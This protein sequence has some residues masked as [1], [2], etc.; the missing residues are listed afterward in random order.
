MPFLVLVHIVLIA[1]CKMENPAID[2]F[3]MTLDA[4]LSD[5]NK[6]DGSLLVDDDNAGNRVDRIQIINDAI[7]K[8]NKLFENTDDKTNKLNVTHE[9]LLLTQLRSDIKIAILE[10]TQRVSAIE[11]AASDIKIAILEDTNAILEETQRVSAI[12]KAASDIEKAIQN[13]TYFSSINDVWNTKSVSFEEMDAT[14]F[15]RT[16]DP[17]TMP[18]EYRNTVDNANMETNVAASVSSRSKS[19]QSSSAVDI[20]GCSREF[21]ESAH[22]MPHSR[23]CASLWCPIVKWV[24]IIQD[25]LNLNDTRSES[26]RWKYFKKCIHGSAKCAPTDTAAVDDITKKDASTSSFIK[27]SE[28]K[29][30]PV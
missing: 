25:D 21:A 28:D 16:C 4:I 27:A 17:N 13:G 11:K 3:Q 20:F 14:F 30:E 22:L 26:H 29:D 8:L 2:K 5:V 9:I 7:E 12:E 1:C 15:D 10:E 24:L 19:K 6:P 18:A 23:F